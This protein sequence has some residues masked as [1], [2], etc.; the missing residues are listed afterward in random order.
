[1]GLGAKLNLVLLSV[2]LFG[3]V[4]FYFLS[5]PFLEEQARQEVLTRARIMM[6]S[7]AGTRKYTAEEIAPL[8]AGQMQTTFHPQTVAAYA[9]AKNFEVMRA[10]FPD[11]SYREASLNPT[12]PNARAV[13]WEADIINEFRS[14]PEKR[15]MITYRDTP[16]GR[17]MYLA[18]PIKVEMRC[19]ACHSTW[20]TAPKSQIAAYGMNNGFGWKLDETVGAQIVTVPM[21]VALEQAH[22]TRLFFMKLLTLM[23]VILAVLLNVL[24]RVVVLQPISRMSH[25]AGE[26]SMGKT[27]VPEYRKAGSDEIAS[28]SASFNRMRRTVEEAMKMLGDSLK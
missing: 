18:H 25:I 10:N 9:A 14:S 11:Y 28:L 8:L 16:R 27:G 20:E 23:F 7:A 3:L 12:N 2:F 6:D 1:M 4:L 5:A 21:S 13:D 22:D 17:F 15:D 26:V 19:L 24:L